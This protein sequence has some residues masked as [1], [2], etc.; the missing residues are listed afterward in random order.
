VDLVFSRHATRAGTVDRCCRGG[1]LP[2]DLYG[3]VRTG[4]SA[5]SQTSPTRSGRFGEALTGPE[6]ARGTLLNGRRAFSVVA[7]ERLV[8]SAI[9]RRSSRHRGATT[10][11]RT[12]VSD[13]DASVLARG[14]DDRRAAAGLPGPPT[15]A[16]A[17][18]H[19][20]RAKPREIAGRRRRAPHRG[21]RA[22]R[23]TPASRPTPARRTRAGP[24]RWC[25][26]RCSA[27]SN[28]NRSLTGGAGSRSARRRLAEL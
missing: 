10:A 12:D 2:S 24:A 7:S 5:F 21:K 16:G 23:L 14:S 9:F 4:A 26:A 20:R 13:V 18:G 1:R 28:A 19:R 25:S 15:G 3:S 8:E 11:D 6:G 22:R 17:T 27:S